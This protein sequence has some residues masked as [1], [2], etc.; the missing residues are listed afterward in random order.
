M[1]WQKSGVRA[2]GG[3]CINGSGRAKRA[4]CLGMVVARPYYLCADCHQGRCPLDA[5]LGFCAGGLSS[6]LSGLLALLG[7]EF[8]FEAVPTCWRG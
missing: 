7:S 6:G 3:Q 1:R 8:V 5:E 2:A 4:H